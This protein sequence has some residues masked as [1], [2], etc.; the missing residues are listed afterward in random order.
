MGL[1]ITFNGNFVPLTMI[2]REIEQIEDSLDQITAYMPALT[3]LANLYSLMQR[4]LI[5]GAV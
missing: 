5:S 3:L 4:R 1:P 2:I